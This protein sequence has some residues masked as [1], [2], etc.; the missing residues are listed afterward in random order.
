MGYKNLIFLNN[1]VLVPRGAIAELR[2]DLEDNALVVPLTTTKGAGHNP[3]QVI[4]CIPYSAKMTMIC[5]QNLPSMFSWIDFA[6]QSIVTSCGLKEAIEDYVNNVW[7]LQPIQ[8]ALSRR[9][10]KSGTLE[11]SCDE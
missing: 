1:D 6:P 9:F 4:Y 7:N 5:Y 8:N 2:T 10:S 3:A 11:V